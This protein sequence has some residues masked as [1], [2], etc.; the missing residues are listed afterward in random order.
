LQPGEFLVGGYSNFLFS[1]KEVTAA[2]MENAITLLA[3]FCDVAAVDTDAADIALLAPTFMLG[4]Y[5][6]PW[7]H[8]RRRDALLFFNIFPPISSPR[9]VSSRTFVLAHPR[10]PCYFNPH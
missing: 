4:W 6:D 10:V 8:T 3:P 1:F 5:G 2:P 7:R 9:L